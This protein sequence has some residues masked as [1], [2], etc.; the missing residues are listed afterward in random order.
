MWTMQI[1]SHLLMESLTE[2]SIF[3]QWNL[4][5]FFDNFLGSF[6][7]LYHFHPLQKHLNIN[8]LIIA[9]SS[10]ETHGFQFQVDSH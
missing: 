3:A 8:G 10:P 1:W 5:T 6:T 4:Y 9:E 2:I 7:F